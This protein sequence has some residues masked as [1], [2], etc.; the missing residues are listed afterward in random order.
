MNERAKEALL[1]WRQSLPG[2]I[3]LLQEQVPHVASKHLAPTQCQVLEAKAE[4]LSPPLRS[5]SEEWV[6]EGYQSFLSAFSGLPRLVFLWGP[7][8]I[9]SALPFSQEVVPE[10]LG[11][12]DPRC[13][14]GGTGQGL[15]L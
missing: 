12:C 15:R 11:S 8:V 13:F 5:L 2:A 3:S 6:G 10:G 9:R 7:E 4:E 14:L 1:R